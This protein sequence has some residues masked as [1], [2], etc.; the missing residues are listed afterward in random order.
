[1]EPHGRTWAFQKEKKTKEV[2]SLG[3]RNFHAQTGI[4]LAG[5]KPEGKDLTIQ[6]IE[7][8]D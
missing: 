8:R 3:E 4:L 5:S 7:L 2:G 6:G 1:M